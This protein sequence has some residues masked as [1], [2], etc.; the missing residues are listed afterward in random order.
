M[1]ENGIKAGSWLKIAECYL[2]NSGTDEKAIIYVARDL[3][4]HQS[5]PEETEILQVK[6]VS[7][8]HLFGMVM[9]GEIMDAPTIIAALKA[10]LLMDEGSI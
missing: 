5:N 7:F 9:R 8:G 10:K 1:E 2:S 3:S 6:K 4:F